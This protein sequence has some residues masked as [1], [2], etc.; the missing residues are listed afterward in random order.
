[1]TSKQS[2]LIILSSIIHSRPV[3]ILISFHI[4]FTQL[5]FDI[6]IPP[7]VLTE[8]LQ[9]Q[10]VAATQA[11]TLL[12][13]SDQSPK[14]CRRKKRNSTVVARLGTRPFKNSPAQF[15]ARYGACSERES[16]LLRDRVPLCG[17]PAQVLVYTPIHRSAR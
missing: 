1:M 3:S 12:Q 13:A 16:R 5:F 9:E 4:P 15:F 11:T 10:N 17:S 2:Q 7:S 14:V 6:R 8:P